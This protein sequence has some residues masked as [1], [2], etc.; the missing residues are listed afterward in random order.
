MKT[1][2]KRTKGREEGRGKKKGRRERGGGERR[3]GGG[4]TS[5]GGWIGG[6]RGGG[7]VGAGRG[8]RRG[9]RRLVSRRRPPGREEAAKARPARLGSGTHASRRGARPPATQDRL[10]SA[11]AP[12]AD[13]SPHAPTLPR[14]ARDA[15]RALPGRDR[16]APT[17]LPLPPRARSGRPARR[18]PNSIFTRASF[19]GSVPPP[20]S[21]LPPPPTRRRPLA[22]P[23]GQASSRHR[24]LLRRRRRRR[25]GLLAGL[26]RLLRGP[27]GYPPTHPRVVLRSPSEL[28][29][30][31]PWP[32]STRGPPSEPGGNKG[33][34]GPVD[35]AG[36]ARRG[37]GARGNSRGEGA[38]RGARRRPTGRSAPPA[39]KGGVGTSFQE[40]RG[41]CI[42]NR[43]G[44]RGEPSPF[45]LGFDGK[46]GGVRERSGKLI[47]P[48]PTAAAPT[49]F[50]L[51]TAP[52]PRTTQGRLPGAV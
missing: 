8:E 22:S 44:W 1:S 17:R 50:R 37:P 49:S 43:S 4:R 38:V 11:A 26:H 14:S 2:R 3:S 13:L 24:G 29:L 27:R 10:R 39:G 12:R 33:R 28:L 19:P 46:T 36:G 23:R 7:G 35:R 32:P 25:P 5:G 51:T 41:P 15:G 31:L 40:T 30:S 47:T 9:G 21:P 34:S 45:S 52:L 42:G 18:A 20:T 16:T 6:R 48:S